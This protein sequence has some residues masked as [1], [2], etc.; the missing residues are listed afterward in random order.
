MSTRERFILTEWVKDKSR[1]VVDA[2]GKPVEIF[3]QPLDPAFWGRLPEGVD[4]RECFIYF[5]RREGSRNA[6]VLCDTPA[7]LFFDD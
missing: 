3:A 7:G 1:K 2:E 6:S 5:A 4:P